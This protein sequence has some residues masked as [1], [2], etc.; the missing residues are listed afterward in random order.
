MVRWAD[1]ISCV[2]RAY[3]A[4]TIGGG[5][6]GCRQSP[7]SRTSVPCVWR[8]ALPRSHGLSSG[9]R[10]AYESLSHVPTFKKKRKAVGLNG[11]DVSP[12]VNLS[13]S[14]NSSRCSE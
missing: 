6:E 12:R 2:W 3:T 11:Q 10:G 13:R 5:A 9:H 7:Y 14:E 8:A 1:M 4:G